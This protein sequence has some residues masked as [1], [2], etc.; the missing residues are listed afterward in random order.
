VGEDTSDL[1]TPELQVAKHFARTAVDSLPTVGDFV[2]AKVVVGQAQAIIQGVIDASFSSNAQIAQIVAD[3][4][5]GMAGAAT[6]DDVR[7]EVAAFTG[8]FAT[9]LQES[10]KRLV[11]LAETSQAT[12]PAILDAINTGNA[13]DDKAGKKAS[14]REWLAILVALVLGV[15]SLIV[16][17]VK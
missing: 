7:A 15:A 2:S 16:V 3:Q 8:T 1:D 9:Y 14:R 6:I 11:T 13:N 4:S 10:N 12:L 17:I 5:E